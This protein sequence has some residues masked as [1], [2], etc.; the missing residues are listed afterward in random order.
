MKFRKPIVLG[1]AVLTLVSVNQIFAGT[2]VSQKVIAS[3]SKAI[4][5]AS[6][7]L[8]I[9]MNLRE[10][11]MQEKAGRQNVVV[12]AQD[13]ASGERMEIEIDLQEEIQDIQQELEEAQQEIRAARED[14]LVEQEFNMH[15][16]EMRLLEA[17]KELEKLRHLDEL[18]NLKNLNV[19]ISI[20][21]IGSRPFL[22]IVVDDLDFK[23][24]FEMH[25]NRNYGVLVTG[26]IEN[27][28]ADQANLARGDIIMEF[29]GQKVRYAGMLKNLIDAK[30]I[31]EEVRLQIFR[32]EQVK[33]VTLTMQPKMVSVPEPPE[34]EDAKGPETVPSVT[35]TA[36]TVETAEEDWDTDWEDEDWEDIDWG[37][38]DFFE[39]DF[40]SAGY[41][42]G[43]WIP[44][45]YMMKMED[46]N[47]VVDGL[48]FNPLPEQGILL[49]GGGGKGPIGNG[50]FIGGIGAGYGIDRNINYTLNTGTNVIRRLSFSVGFGGVTLDKR[51]R[52]SD[53]LALGTG[54]MLG[55]G[56]TTM[57]INQTTGDYDWHEL[58]TRFSEG[59]NSY[60]KLHKGYLMF[61]PRA[62][63]L[64]RITKWFAIRSEAG[65]LMGYSFKRGWE[66]EVA[67]ESFEV[68]NAP[69]S[70][71]MGGFTFSIGPWFGF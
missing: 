41:G 50:W 3:V 43:S 34:A 22:G 45:W 66:A 16:L 60:L 52:L 51:Y 35:D 1:I 39:D 20:P 54:F 48:G 23:Q 12:V 63:F 24:A 15:D 65:Y 13:T 55:G 68:I 70:D 18:E 14:S 28:P 31:G 29:D 49:N 33:T 30:K 25:Y 61:Q 2:S 47:T 71:F 46:I 4:A 62:T 32:N 36:E 6:S 17:L 27:T 40:F 69:Q 53:H 38:G 67:D 8:P 7:S 5:D 57:K 42:G 9:H 21:E 26:V 10:V 64:V 19:R 37:T 59:K 44:V 11:Y 58:D 56:G